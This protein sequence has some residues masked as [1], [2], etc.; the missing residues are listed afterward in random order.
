MPVTHRIRYLRKMGKDPNE[1][2]SLHELSNMSGVPERILQQV[3]N[4]GV[5]AARSNPQSIRVKGTFAKNPSMSA[6]PRSGRLS[7]E[8][9]A[10]ARVYSFLDKGTTYKTTDADLAKIAGY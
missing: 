1:S 7:D 8:Q 2:Y 9:W 6:V 3:F 4:R 10:Y 5:G